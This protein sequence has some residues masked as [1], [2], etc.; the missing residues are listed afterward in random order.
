M[1]RRKCEYSQVGREHQWQ[2]ESGVDCLAIHC[3]HYN[4]PFQEAVIMV[5][6]D[7]DFA[8]CLIEM[9]EKMNLDIYPLVFHESLDKGGK[10][11]WGRIRVYKLDEIFRNSNYKNEKRNDLMRWYI[12]PHLIQ[13]YIKDPTI[14]VDHQ[15]RFQHQPQLAVPYYLCDGNLR[16]K[17]VIS[18]QLYQVMLQ[19][20]KKKPMEFRKISIS[21]EMVDKARLEGIEKG[22]QLG[23]VEGIREE[24]ERRKAEVSSSRS[25]NN[26]TPMEDIESG[27]MPYEGQ[28]IE[29]AI[30][31]DP[32]IP[33]SPAT[34]SQ[35]PV[36]APLD[37]VVMPADPDIDLEDLDD[38]G[39]IDVNPVE[40]NLEYKV[41]LYVIYILLI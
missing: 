20:M 17:S 1:N 14:I 37:S 40:E 6:S 33:V 34:I 19:F 4:T 15:Y 23:G 12:T 26:A 5:T 9:K 16:T 10:S 22:I 39:I 32:L 21:D 41:C 3:C 13:K 38:Y 2:T 36:D 8:K 7:R 27:I 28:V 25:D 18:D 29:G 31:P 24:V 35:N 11:V 30:K